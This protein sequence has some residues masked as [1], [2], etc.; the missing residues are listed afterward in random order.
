MHHTTFLLCE[1]DRDL[2]RQ[3]YRQSTS[4][5]RVSQKKY[6]VEYCNILRMVQYYQCNILP[7]TFMYIGVC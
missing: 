3:T 4:R 2:V 6:G 5:Y 1:T 7:K